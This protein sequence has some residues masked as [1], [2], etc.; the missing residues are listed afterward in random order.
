ML[1]FGAALGALGIAEHAG[2]QVAAA[3]QP[4]RL[5]ARGNFV[6]RNAHVMTMEPGTGDIIGGDVH[7]KD[8]VIA[9]IGQYLEAPGANTIKGEG[10][11]LIHI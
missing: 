10:L 1:R 3:P 9:G 2:A 4:V 6:I 11:S 8:G 5:P 7:V